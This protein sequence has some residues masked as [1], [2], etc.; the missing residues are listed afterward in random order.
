MGRV[1]KMC[2]PTLDESVARRIAIEIKARDCKHDFSVCA[3]V[4][5]KK[6]HDY[7]SRIAEAL[8]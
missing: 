2:G 5:R 7:H 3:A 6:L 8:K 1:F 4:I